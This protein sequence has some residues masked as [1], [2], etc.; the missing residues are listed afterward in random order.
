MS[1]LISDCILNKQTASSSN[2]QSS[3]GSSNQSHCKYVRAL[4]VFRHSSDLARRSAI[5]LPSCFSSCSSPCCCL[6]G[7]AGT[8]HSSYP[9]TSSR[10]LE[11][12]ASKNKST[13]HQG[14]GGLSL[15]QRRINGLC[16]GDEA[17]TT[18]PF[19]ERQLFLCLKSSDA[20][21]RKEPQNAGNPAPSLLEVCFSA[22]LKKSFLY[23]FLKEREESCAHSP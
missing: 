16:V 12:L 5:L 10:N 8:W 14:F 22:Q 4:Q 15:L 21:S 13:Q 6:P 20:D 7:L 18:W 3:T 11:L 2:C 23:L 1:A 17:N 9:S 19:V